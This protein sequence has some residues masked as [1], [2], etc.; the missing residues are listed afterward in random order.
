MGQKKSYTRE[1]H[2]IYCLNKGEAAYLGQQEISRKSS[3]HAGFPHFHKVSTASAAHRGN[4]PC[5]YILY[6]KKTD[7]AREN[8]EYFF[9][10]ISTSGFYVFYIM[11]TNVYFQKEL[12]SPP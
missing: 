10:F 7:F 8:G 11:L 12:C 4:I 5:G 1:K 2:K 3:I 9:F 6:L